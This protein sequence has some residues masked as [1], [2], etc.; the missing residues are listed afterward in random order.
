MQEP[1]EGRPEA[2]QWLEGVQVDEAA[3]DDMQATLEHAETVR[4]RLLSALDLVRAFQG[5]VTFAHARARLAAVLVVQVDYGLA[6]C[7]SAVYVAQAACQ[8]AT[9][10]LVSR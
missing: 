8:R 4:M 5:C 1:M 9:T 6:G 7:C 2:E 10:A 3:V